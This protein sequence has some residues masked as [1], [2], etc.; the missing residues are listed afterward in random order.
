MECYILKSRN[1]RS[2]MAIQCVVVVVAAVASRLQFSQ[3]CDA[4]FIH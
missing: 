2:Y 4:K 3:F 1:S